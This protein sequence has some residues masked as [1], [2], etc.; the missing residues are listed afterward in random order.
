MP[1]VVGYRPSQLRD[2]VDVLARLDSQALD[3]QRV[4]RPTV[5]GSRYCKVRSTG[6]R[7]D[8]VNGA[9]KVIYSFQVIK[10]YEADF[11]TQCQ[12]R[13]MDRSK[14]EWTLNIESLEDVD[15]LGM[16]QALNCTGR[17]NA[18]R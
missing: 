10:R 13:W 16:W 12:L 15:G 18:D 5:I 1:H 6:S 17:L 8:D 9:V 7:E 2:R 14:R 11:D 4:S 3:G